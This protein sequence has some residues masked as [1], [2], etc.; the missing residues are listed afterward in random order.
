MDLMEKLHRY[1]QKSA[2]TPVSPILFATFLLCLCPFVKNK[3]DGVDRISVA[4]DVGWWVS[5]KDIE[6]LQ[7]KIGKC[8]SLTQQWAQNNAVVCD[9]DKTEIVLLSD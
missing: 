9:I 6:E 7:C 3:V 1:I 8:A 4:D 5:G 2:G